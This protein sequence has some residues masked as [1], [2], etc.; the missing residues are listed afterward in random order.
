VHLI[1]GDSR[2]LVERTDHGAHRA[3]GYLGVERG[4]LELAVTEQSLDHPDIDAVFQ[5]MSGEAVPAM[6]SAT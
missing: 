3:R 6:S 2:Q 1:G 5:Q 4:C